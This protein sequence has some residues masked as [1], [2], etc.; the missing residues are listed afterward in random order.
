MRA[1][2]IAHT[3]CHLGD[4]LGNGRHVSGLAPAEFEE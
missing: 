1:M 2:P 4:C 3:A